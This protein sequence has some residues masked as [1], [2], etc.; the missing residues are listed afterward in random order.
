MAKVTKK[1]QKKVDNTI[2]GQSPLNLLN[3][4]GVAVPISDIDIAKPFRGIS[5]IKSAGDTIKVSKEEK[6]FLVKEVQKCKQ[7]IIYFAENYFY[8]VSYK[9]KHVIKL[10]DKQKLM[11]KSF[12]ENNF[13]V[14]LAARQSGKCLNINNLCKFRDKI[15]GK[16]FEM[17]IGEFFTLIKNNQK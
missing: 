12:I 5:N 2:K 7:D 9:G 10:F 8:I 11:L 13:T 15:T 4:P 3:I 14:T 6:E 17:S 1:K 16:E